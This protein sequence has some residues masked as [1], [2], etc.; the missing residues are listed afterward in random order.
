LLQG[1]DLILEIARTI[2]QNNPP[3]TPNNPTIQAYLSTIKALLS[4]PIPTT[5]PTVG[6]V[7]PEG[8]ASPP[9]PPPD[10]LPDSLPDSLPDLIPIADRT[11]RVSADNLHR[12]MDL[13]GE[14]L[15]AAN[16][17][18][19]FSDS[20]LKLKTRQTELNKILEALQQS[21]PKHQENLR[22]AKV[23]ANECSQLL[24]DRH[25]ELETF[26]RHSSNLADRLYREVISSQMRPFSDIG[27]GW[28][29]MVRDLARQLGK[30][31][32]L[33]IVGPA[34]RVD[35]DILDRLE[36]PLTHLIRN[37]ID[38]GIE[39]PTDRQLAGKPAQGRIYIEASHRSGL[40]LITVRDDGRGIDRA[41]LAQ[42]I[43]AKQLATPAMLAEMS[44]AEQLEFLYLPGFSTAN[45]V[46]EVSGRGV[47]LDIVNSLIQSLGGSIQ[48]SH[49]AGQSLTF[50]LQLPLTLSVLRSLVIEVGGET[51]ALPL[52][53][54]DRVFTASRDQVQFT[55]N[56]PYIWHNDQAIGLVSGTSILG[57]LA[58][59]SS[60]L[61][62]TVLVIQ[63]HQDHYGLIID[64]AIGEQRIVLR[65]L[66]RRL[67]KVP[68]I[69]AAALLNDGTPLLVLD[70]DDLIRSMAKQASE[71][72]QFDIT[73]D[74]SAQTLIPAKRILIVD[75]SITVREMER[76]LL[77]NAHYHVTVAVDGMDAWNLL[78]TMS[79]DLIVTDVDMPRL[80]GIE[81]IRQIKAQPALQAIPTIIVSYKDRDTDRLQGLEAGADYYL[82][83][84][85]F[86]DDS[87]LQ[88]V[89][90][91][92]G[93]STN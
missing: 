84:S 78:Q 82:T 43:I 6:C 41:A 70:M 36:T 10:P 68:N 87:L 33:E 11:M 75:D 9:E 27:Q 85:S 71:E 2:E 64:R 28:P 79:F 23:K 73:H 72:S 89:I 54:A 5:I 88:A 12:L 3:P 48:I 24:A 76:K 4:N 81:L 56:S 25:S 31:V 63:H 17:L 35:R 86:H 29:R 20:L 21:S 57:G 47:G 38:H 34:T 13:A 22:R 62:L 58:A 26:A 67:G 15:V 19:P 55:Q 92:I 16:W 46:T 65:P 14:S 45:T 42:K 53:R 93:S 18:E 8:N 91:L 52:A 77:E 37:A 59:A 80:T 66:D 61:Q 50:Q 39:S 60:S 40:L 51:Y 83:K 32:R 49:V 7:V 69:S 1:G 44:E 90:D 74:S 30:Q